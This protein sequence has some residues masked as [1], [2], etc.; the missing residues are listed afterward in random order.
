MPIYPSGARIASRYEVVQGP[1]EKPDL[2]GGIGIVYLCL[3]TETDRPISLKTLRPEY[4]PDRA[5]RD[6]FL[7]AG[8]HWID[9]GTHPQVVRCYQVLRF[10][11]EVFLVLELVAKHPGRNDASLRAW[12]TPGYPLPVDQAILFALQ[13]ARGM[14]HATHVI[15]GFV[16]RD[17]KP[18]NI[19]VGADRLSQAPTHR[20]R[21]TDFGLT[22]VLQ[23]TAPHITQP[24]SDTKHGTRNTE[25]VIR[26]TEHAIRTTHLTAGTTALPLYTA[27]E[28]WRAQPLTTATD[29][30][31]L[32]CFLHEML[33]GQRAVSGHNLAALQRA[34][35]AGEIRPL[36]VDLP[37]EVCGL[38]TGCL[39]VEPGERYQDWEQVQAALAAAYEAVTG[40]PAPA[41]E[42]VAVLGRAE[43]VAA[44]WSYSEI[45]TSC[46]GVGQAEVALGYFQRA[47]TLARDERERRLEGA[48]LNNLGLTYAALGN[49]RRAIECHEQCLTIHPETGDRRGERNVLG[50]LGVAY[51]N[52]GDARQA[53]GYFEQAL[54]VDREIEDPREDSADLDNP[55]EVCRL[56]GDTGRAIRHHRQALVIARE[57]GDRCGE[58]A[59]LGNLGRAYTALGD[60]RR[61]IRYFE[62]QLV[63]TR[64]MDDR[65]GEGAALGN[66][67]TACACVG[68]AHSAI[69]Y[70]E[71][72]LVIDRET[73]DRRGEGKDLGNLATAYNNMG[74]TQRAIQ[75]YEQQLVIAREI[76][77]RRGE[78]AA[79]G[80][81]G[82]ACA[83]LDDTR[84]AIGYYEQ[85]L[86]IAREIGAIDVMAGLLFNLAPL[87]A[88]QGKTSRAI[89]LAQYAARIYT[90]IGHA[91][92]AQRAQQLV[93]QLKRT[94]R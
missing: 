11:P 38:V 37:E 78:A 24:T 16:H 88:H 57:A 43:R 5:A 74:D 4:L 27:P 90:K 47:H 63:I 7:R 34:H 68:D 62:Q 76:G 49:T 54:A 61:A 77:D 25:H 8:T 69:G 70:Y 75:C 14:N 58:S 21:V 10:D 32:G 91:Q 67:G 33:A 29:I 20:L 36:P 59:H 46:L 65:H 15:P 64:E 93:A 50:N 82:D 26:N 28:Q 39:A 79:L 84:R 80:H 92:H 12:L 66:L 42:P 56:M 55:G 85:A 41:A 73:R 44:G 6:H 35:C 17:L 30:Y 71:Q 18:E 23:A 86:A 60:K 13:I 9:L 3:D 45:G 51:N 22:A 52:L 48:A 2:A 53:I 87:C 19:L 94:P 89:E 40:R 1:R 72:A 83:G 81:L 31:A